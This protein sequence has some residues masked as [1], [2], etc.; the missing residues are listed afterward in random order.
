MPYTFDPTSFGGLPFAD[1]VK[2][3]DDAR[4]LKEVLGKYGAFDLSKDSGA[5]RLEL[6]GKNGQSVGTTDKQAYINAIDRDY[7]TAAE[8]ARVQSAQDKAAPYAAKREQIARALT[9]L[10]VR[11]GTAQFDRLLNKYNSPNSESIF[12]YGDASAYRM[13]RDAVAQDSAMITGEQ[14]A[15]SAAGSSGRS[16]TAQAGQPSWD[17]NS[18]EGVQRIYNF[19]TQA[20]N[21]YG[22][23]NAMDE[24]EWKRTG[25]FSDT[26]AAYEYK[27]KLDEGARAKANNLALAGHNALMLD[28]K[29][30]VF[31]PRTG[32]PIQYKGADGQV[33]AT[34]GMDWNEVSEKGRAGQLKPTF[35]PMAQGSGIGGTSNGAT[36]TPRRATNT[37]F[38]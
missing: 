1:R 24:A 8:K 6:T 34:N 9:E 5:G 30:I 36:A 27:S 22:D 38:F 14:G 4:I 3:E 10:G 32:N 37:Y 12:A 23:V 21:R 13:L 25:Q 16:S 26:N 18:Q 29:N 20:K 7:Q 17:P 19:R 35:S 33:Y 2:S 31:D 11:Q 15:G 28:R